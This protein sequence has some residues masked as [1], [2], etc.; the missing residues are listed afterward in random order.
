MNRIKA[1][2]LIKKYREGNLSAD[3]KLV[4]EKWYAT[5]EET[6]NL[7]LE[8]GELV[9]NLDDIWKTIELNTTLPDKRPVIKTIWKRVAGIAA[10]LSL[11]IISVIYFSS[12]SKSSPGSDYRSIAKTIKPGGNKAT[13]T[14]SNGQIIILD[15]ASNGKLLE[16]AGISITKTADGQIIYT[17][18]GNHKLTD[19]PL[20]NTITTPT[21]GQ[22]QIQ[23][24]DGSK[25]W[26][27]AQSSLR[28]PSFFNDK[29]RLVT[30]TGEAYFEIAKSPKKQNFKVITIN[31]T[32]EVLGTHF[33]INAYSNEASVKTT[34]LEGQVKVSRLL[35]DKNVEMPVL[36]KPGQQSSVSAKTLNVENVAPAQFTSWKDGSFAF[37]D[38]DLKTVM[39][40]LSRWYNINVSYEGTIPNLEFSGELNR[41]LNLDQILDV[42]SFYQVHFKMEGKNLIVAPSNTK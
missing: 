12:R 33:N 31:Q 10:I 24:P 17:A 22:Y 5:L 19:K 18:N 39:R 40:T 8:P 26:L 7:H 25:V 32:L 27:N 1:E 29:E 9:K 36:L 2:E 6:S 34:L 20:I 13:L 28:Y 16:Q 42:L 38:T 4:L 41:N 35:P 14:L 21:G 11:V 23:L 15:S 37:K 30:L 3:E